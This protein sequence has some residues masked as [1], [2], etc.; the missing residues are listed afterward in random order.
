MEITETRKGIHGPERT[1]LLGCGLLLLTGFIL[2]AGV[3]AVS[4]VAGKNFVSNEKIVSGTGRD[5]IAVL[6]VSGELNEDDAVSIISSSGT[7]G[8]FSF[9]R[10]LETISQ[11]PD[12]KALVL[13]VNSPGGSAVAAEEMYQALLTFKKGGKK[14]VVS[15]G[16]MAASGGYYISLAADKIIASQATTTGSIGVITQVT[17]VSGLYDKLGLKSEVYKSGPEKDILSGTKE[18]SEEDKKIIQSVIDDA[19]QVFLDRVSTGRNMDKELVKKI[20]DGRIYSGSQA[21]DLKLVDKIGDFDDAVAEA[22]RLVGVSNAQVVEFNNTSFLSQ[23]LGLLSKKDPVTTSL[24][25]LA[26]TP[27][28]SI[29]YQLSF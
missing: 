11:D 20:A 18:P 2:T 7:T 14:I 5:K 10:Q 12:V 23:F 26:P 1:I 29:R 13:R 25:A 27:G 3:F 19:Y 4:F 6:Y 24:E 16:E 22:K 28:I 21:F 9:K 17:N 8:A 15:M